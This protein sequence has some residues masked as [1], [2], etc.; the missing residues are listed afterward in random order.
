MQNG[1]KMFEL[2]A[3]TRVPDGITIRSGYSAN[4]S[5]V[6]DKAGKALSCDETAVEFKDGKAYVYVL[7]SKP[8]DVEHQQFE[9]REGTVGISDGLYMEVKSGIKDGD[10]LRGI[11]K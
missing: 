6:L 10:L 1:A 9:R 3:T 4:A 11:Q 8:D 7:T 5:I 2:K